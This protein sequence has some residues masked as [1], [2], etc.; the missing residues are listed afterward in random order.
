MVT[1]S[2]DFFFFRDRRCATPANGVEKDENALGM[3]TDESAR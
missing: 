1:C 2:L 3:K